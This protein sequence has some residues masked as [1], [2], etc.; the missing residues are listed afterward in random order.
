MGAHYQYGYLPSVKGRAVHITK[1]VNRKLNRLLLC[2][3]YV[4]VWKFL[5]HFGLISAWWIR[6]ETLLPFLNT[7][8]YD[9]ML[10]CAYNVLGIR[11]NILYILIYGYGNGWNAWLH[12]GLPFLNI[13][14][15]GNLPPPKELK[16]QSSWTG[17]AVLPA[18]DAGCSTSTQPY[19]VSR[20]QQ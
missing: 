18:P 13:L 9:I 19:P 1:C 4:R 2:V 16:S 3:R 14:G 6:I 11:I 5:K 10:W 7:A 20:K 8:Q 17:P 15:N 12:S